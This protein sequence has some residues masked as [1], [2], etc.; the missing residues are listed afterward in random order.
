VLARWKAS[1]ASF[2]V[3]LMPL[4]TALSAYWLLREPL[5]LSML[6]GGILVLGGVVVGILPPRRSSQVDEVK[7]SP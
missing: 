1:A 6:T 7:A 2:Q 4:I 3:V 5:T